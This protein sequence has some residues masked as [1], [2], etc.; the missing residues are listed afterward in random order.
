MLPAFFYFFGLGSSGQASYRA[1]TRAG[2]APTKVWLPQKVTGV[3]PQPVANGSSSTLAGF[4]VVS[5]A[6]R[7]ILVVCKVRE[8]SAIG[9]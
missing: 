2:P 4:P 3:P 1:A 7:E 5:A 8:L 6:G 9:I